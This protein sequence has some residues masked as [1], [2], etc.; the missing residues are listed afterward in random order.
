MEEASPYILTHTP[1]AF[2]RMIE[3]N[4]SFGFET[5]EHKLKVNGRDHRKVSAVAIILE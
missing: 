4:Y 1:A 5:N 3:T 2:Q